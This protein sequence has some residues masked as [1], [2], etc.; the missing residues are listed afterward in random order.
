MTIHR[1]RVGVPAFHGMPLRNL[2]VLSAA[3]MID[4]VGVVCDAPK[5]QANRFL[6]FLCPNRQVAKHYESPFLLYYL[7]LIV[8]GRV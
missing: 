7:T 8:F 1:G 6:L 5:S 3:V 4:D 2:A